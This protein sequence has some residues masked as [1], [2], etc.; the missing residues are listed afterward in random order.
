[1]TRQA[2]VK[3]LGVLADA[4]LVDSHRL[5]KEMHFRLTPD[6]LDDAVAW[7]DAVGRE[8]QGRL[9]ALERHLAKRRRC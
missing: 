6:P 5:G 3:H 1:M 4:G 8:W 9:D 2:V 7:I